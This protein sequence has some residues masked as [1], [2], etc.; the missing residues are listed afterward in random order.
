MAVIF[1]PIRRKI[2]IA[3]A[4]E[5][6]STTSEAPGGEN[7]CPAAAMCWEGRINAEK[8]EG[9]WNKNNKKGKRRIEKYLCHREG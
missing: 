6:L 7:P 3:Q 4:Y 1:F 8:T 5:E 2:L 9:H